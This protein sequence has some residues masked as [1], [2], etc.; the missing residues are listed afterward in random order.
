MAGPPEGRLQ[1]DASWLHLRTL[2][3]QSPVLCVFFEAWKKT[4]SESSHLLFD[5]CLMSLERNKHSKSFSLKVASV[6]LRRSVHT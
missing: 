2:A 1:P 4:S 5:P 6:W 3:H